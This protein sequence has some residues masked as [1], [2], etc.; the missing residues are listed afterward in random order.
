MPKILEFDERARRALERGVDKL[1]DTVK[2]TL[3]PRGR[4]VVLDKKWGAPTITNDGVTV[5]REIEL[6]DP[7]ENLG[8]QLTK[9]VATK[10]NDIAGDGTTTATVLAQAMVHE[11]LRAVAAGA[12]PMALK[13]GMDAAAQAVN[14]ELL[15]IAR[16]VDSKEDMASV[17]TISSRDEVIGGLLADAFD[18]VGKDGVITVEES[19]TMGTELEFTEGMQFDKGYISAYFVTD[20]E[21][22]E[23]VLEDPYI[24]LHQGKISAVADL[25]PLLEKVI[26]SGKPLFIL[27]EDVEGEA[28]STL[29]VNKIRGTFNAAAVKSPAFGDRR[30][31]MME[32]IATLTGAQVVAP[33]VGLKLD[34]IGLEVLGTA[35]RVVITKDN[36][37]IV[38]GAGDTAAVTGRINQIK[39]EIENTD[40]DW[41]REKL[42]ERLAK[43]AGGVCIIK[44]GAATE[45][46]LKEK[47][48]RIE[49]AVSATRAAIEEGIVAGGGSALIHA[50]AVLSDGLGLTGDEAAGVRVVR[51]ALDEPL[52][53]IAENGGINGYVVTT[54][55]RELGVGSGYNAATEEY[56]DLVAQGVL[57]PVKVTR[58]AL[59]NASS[60]AGMLLTTETLVVDK[61]E[62][63]EPEAAGHG[64]G[65][66]H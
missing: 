17:A 13:R 58:S 37:T 22:M 53:W 43:L 50:A 62:D 12:N 3:G 45:V 23:T 42:Q 65:H 35:R 11:G 18:K 5:A 31:A 47:K 19:N 48:H 46:E 57:D 41:D 7:F 40:S 54:K 30:K 9:E 2:V 20:P 8:A 39:A 56:G 52:R 59:V 14:D 49:D 34:Q 64:H 27:A 24:L 21:R 60:I 28:L 32:D 51:I 55:V 1:A 29:V 66:G 26:Q 6:D 44:V 25:L 38:D 10:T 15:K 16:E 33:E 63:D 61:P 36:T 4:Y